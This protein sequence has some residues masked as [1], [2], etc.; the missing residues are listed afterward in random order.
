MLIGGYDQETYSQLVNR[1]AKLAGDLN[2][3]DF[4]KV[5]TEFE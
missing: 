4:G 2:I 5:G 1:A 3:H